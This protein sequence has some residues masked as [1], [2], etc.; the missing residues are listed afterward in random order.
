MRV[1]SGV[2]VHNRSRT[3]KTGARSLIR[4]SQAGVNRPYG[5][6]FRPFTK[7]SVLIC[8]RPPERWLETMVFGEPLVSI[9]KSGYVWLTAPPHISGETGQNERNGALSGE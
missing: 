2:E 6:R 3:R 4:I 5:L 8:S 1:L 9:S 7:A